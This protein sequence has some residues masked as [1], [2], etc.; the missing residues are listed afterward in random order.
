VTTQL[1]LINIII[2]KKDEVL[3]ANRLKYTLYNEYC[4][5]REAEFDCD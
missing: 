5:L 4:T 2:I 3:S 1:Q